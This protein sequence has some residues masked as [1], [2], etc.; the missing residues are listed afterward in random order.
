MFQKTQKVF[1]QHIVLFGIF[2]ILKASDNPVY[3]STLSWNAIFKKDIIILWLDLYNTSEYYMFF[4]Q[5]WRRILGKPSKR[6]YTKR[7]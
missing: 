5:M 1:S 6:K 3:K 7:C 4:V 2:K